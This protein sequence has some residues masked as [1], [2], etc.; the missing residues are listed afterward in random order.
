M[1][2]EH[3]RQL[4][5]AVTAERF[6]GAGAGPDFVR[7]VAGWVARRGGFDLH[8]GAVQPGTNGPQPV[9]CCGLSLAAEVW[10]PVPDDAAAAAIAGADPQWNVCRICCDAAAAS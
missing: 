3:P 4:A 2:T 8:R 1:S 7:M 10:R 9:T 5:V 6:G